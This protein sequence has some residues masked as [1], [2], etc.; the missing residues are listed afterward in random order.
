MASR[1]LPLAQV[2]CAEIYT[3]LTSQSNLGLQATLEIIVIIYYGLSYNYKVNL[4]STLLFVFQLHSSLIKTF[5]CSELMR[6]FSE[7][8]FLF[9]S[10][11]CWIIK[12]KTVQVY[13]DPARQ[14]NDTV[15]LFYICCPKIYRT[16]Y[17]LSNLKIT[18]TLKHIYYIIGTLRYLLHYVQLKIICQ[19]L[20]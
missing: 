19:S 2:G 9:L 4:F 6:G 1:F 17:I 13:R 10:R 15:W 8:H 3:R 12:D 7:L 20:C 5:T 14:C 18:C 11:G 16:C